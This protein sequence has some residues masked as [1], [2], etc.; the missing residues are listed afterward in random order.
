MRREAETKVAPTE[1]LPQYSHQLRVYQDEA[2]SP[3]LNASRPAE[4]HRP[5]CLSLRLFLLQ[6][7]LA[8][9]WNGKCS[10]TCSHP[11]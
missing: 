10:V 8:G 5:T 4:L 6:D 3:E 7:E 9:N 1:S 2:R 11:T